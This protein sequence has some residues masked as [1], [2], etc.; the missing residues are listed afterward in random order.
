MGY[1]TYREEMERDA[2][3]SRALCEREGLVEQA[4]IECE[5]TAVR[6]FKAA[7]KKLLA[8]EKAA[9]YTRLEELHRALPRAWTDAQVAKRLAKEVRAIRRGRGEA[10]VLSSEERSW[11]RAKT[12]VT[13]KAKRSSQQKK[14]PKQANTAPKNAKRPYYSVKNAR[15]D[16]D[17]VAKR[18]GV[19]V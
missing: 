10:E 3:I 9:L 12:G 13:P 17:R 6:A 16:L 8:R 19:K 14:K 15:K 4:Q 1:E 11:I 2:K 18:L 7:R 5:E